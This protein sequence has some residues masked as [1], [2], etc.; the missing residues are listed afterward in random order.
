MGWSKLHE[1][2]EH[3]P[4]EAMLFYL[5]DFR[6]IWLIHGVWWKRYVWADHVKCIAEQTENETYFIRSIYRSTQE[7]ADPEDIN[8]VQWWIG[9][10]AIW[11][12]LIS[13]FVIVASCPPLTEEEFR[14]Y[15]NLCIGTGDW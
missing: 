5:Y 13:D 9:I 7:F 11:S 14:N 8:A 2:F 15:Y 10:A 3:A 12:E 1:I 4:L 6:N